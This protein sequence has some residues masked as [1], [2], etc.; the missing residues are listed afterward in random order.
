MNPYVIDPMA[1]DR[2]SQE[3]EPGERAIWAGRPSPGR[4][5]RAALPIALFAIPFTA[6]SLFWMAMA[7][8]MFFASS[9][10]SGSGNGPPSALGLIFP[11]FGLPFLCV[12]LFMLSSPWRAAR[13]AKRGL[14]A[15][16][17]RR[18]IIWN[19]KF[20]GTMQVTSY[21]PDDLTQMEREQRADGSGD[22]IFRRVVR[23][24]PRRGH[25]TRTQTE[26]EG[27]LGVPEVAQLERTVRSALG[28]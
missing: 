3:L 26:A 27:F 11:A 21:R 28:L 25:G 13:G 9:G 16:T 23:L 7:S 10:A 19:A 14:Y 17:D 4:A 24:S 6:F 18:C 22:L 2:L 15:I 8:G 12:G 5:M 1:D 20:G